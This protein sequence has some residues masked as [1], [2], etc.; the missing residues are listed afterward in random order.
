MPHTF[1][2]NFSGPDQV[3]LV[4]HE[5]DGKVFCLA[6]ASQCDTELG[7]RVEAGSVGDGVDND[8]STPHLQAVF[9]RGA[10]LPLLTGSET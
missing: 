8:V 3:A 1:H 2:S 5:D 10:V 9:L 4:A 6:G 7:S